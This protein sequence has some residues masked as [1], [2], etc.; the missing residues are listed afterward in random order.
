MRRLFLALALATLLSS[1]ALAQKTS[2][3]L[4][5][6]SRQIGALTFNATKADKEST[7]FFS[8]TNGNASGKADF[9]QLS[10]CQLDG[11]EVDLHKKKFTINLIAPDRKPAVVQGWWRTDGSV[12]T[13]TKPN[14]QP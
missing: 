10:G 5:K 2:V 4:S 13:I 3:T 12:I 1:A 8:I 14:G 11:I 6:T 7:L 9:P